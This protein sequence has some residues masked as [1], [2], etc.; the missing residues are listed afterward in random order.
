MLNDS[1][2]QIRTGQ[3][4]HEERMMGLRLEKD[5]LDAQ[6]NDPRTRLAR[7]QAAREMEEVPINFNIGKFDNDQDRIFFNRYTK[8]AIENVLDDEDMMLSEDGRILE[9]GSSRTAKRPRY[10]A[11]T[12]ANKLALANQASKLGHSK[13]DMEIDILQQD[14][15]NAKKKKVGGHA[16]DKMYGLQTRLKQEKLTKLME[17]RD[18]PNKQLERLVETNSTITDMQLAAMS[19][20][21]IDDTFYSR[22]NT[23]R[24][25]NNAEIKSLMASNATIGKNMVAVPYSYQDPTT[26][27]VTEQEIYLPKHL[28]ASSPQTLN[29]GDRVF[30]KGQ[31]KNID[32]RLGESGKGSAKLPGGVTLQQ[33]QSIYTRHAKAKDIISAAKQKDMGEEHIKS[34]LLQ[35]GAVSGDEVDGIV[36]LIQTNSKAV[37]DSWQ[38]VINQD[39]FLFGK[40]DW[41]NAGSKGS[42]GGGLDVS[43]IEERL[44][45][46]RKK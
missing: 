37:I 29:M 39:K 27:T 5:K 26:G 46:N 3:Q 4:R 19:D 7:A 31:F 35:G 28:A 10:V 21:N 25:A 13:L 6:Q 17:E 9:K 22:L 15:Y 30:N 36:K 42:G 16:K 11:K 33:A 40:Y 2:R 44:K 1:I 45:A 34:I 43:S 23:V 32:E 8:G 14:I 38:Q 18:D 12:L 20:P 41:F 24:T